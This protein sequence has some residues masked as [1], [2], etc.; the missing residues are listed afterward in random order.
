V[1]SPKSSVCLLNVAEPKHPIKKSIIHGLAE[2]YITDHLVERCVTE[3][4]EQGQAVID[5]WEDLRLIG[6]ICTKVVVGAQELVGVAASSSQIST[7]FIGSFIH[8]LFGNFTKKRTNNQ[9]FI[10]EGLLEYRE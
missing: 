7:F 5:K 10:V 8:G 4:V 3:D 6:E 2:I 9:N 1:E